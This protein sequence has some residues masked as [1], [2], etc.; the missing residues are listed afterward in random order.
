MTVYMYGCQAAPLLY[1]LQGL[2]GPGGAK[3]LS[4]PVN[5]PEP[6]SSDDT[7]CETCP[8]PFPHRMYSQ[9]IDL[10][11]FSSPCQS[12]PLARIGYYCELGAPLGM[13]AAL[14]RGR[15]QENATHDTARRPWT[16]LILIGTIL[17]LIGPINVELLATPLVAPIIEEPQGEGYHDGHWR[18]NRR[19]SY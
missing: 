18:R 4:I 1:L 9:R 8:A 13:G 6:I 12:K 7:W 3:I 5:P 11:C 14:L 16:L 15:V 17:I 10:T 19:I 2:P